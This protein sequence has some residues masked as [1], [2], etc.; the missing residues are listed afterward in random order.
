MVTNGADH[1]ST[2]ARTVAHSRSHRTCRAALKDSAGQIA[3][4]IMW[5]MVR[6]GVILRLRNVRPTAWQAARIAESGRT[7][8]IDQESKKRILR[9]MLEVFL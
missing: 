8:Q 7:L 2:V 5:R 6:M 1:C 4:R 3:A 9:S